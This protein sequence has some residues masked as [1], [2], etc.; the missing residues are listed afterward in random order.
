MWGNNGAFRQ[1]RDTVTPLAR[2]SVKPTSTSTAQGISASDFVRQAESHWNVSATSIISAWGAEVAVVALCMLLY[3]YIRRRWKIIYQPRVKLRKVSSTPSE[4]AAN[5]DQFHL[6]RKERGLTGP[7]SDK[8]IKEWRRKKHLSKPEWYPPGDDEPGHWSSRAPRAEIGFLEWIVP[9][10]RETSVEIM[11]I[12]PKWCRP[13]LWRV[14]PNLGGAARAGQKDTATTV[15]EQDVKLLRMLGLDAVVYLLFLRLLKYLFA[16][17]SVLSVFLALSNYYINTQTPY[18]STVKASSNN[19]VNGSSPQVKTSSN[20]IDNPQ[21]L[22]AANIKSNGLIVHISFE[23]VVTLLVMVFALKASAHHLELIQEWTH[24]NFNEV[25]FKT[26]M[27]TNLALSKSTRNGIR[28]VSDAKLEI[29][30]MVLGTGKLMTSDGSLDHATRGTKMQSIDRDAIDAKVWFAMHNM[31][32][33]HENMEAFKDKYFKRAM[34]AVALETLGGAGRGMFYDSCMD[35]ICG[36]SKT[37]KRRVDEAV[38]KKREIESKQD[39]IR[40]DQKHVK[41][42]DLTGTI[43]SAFITVPTAK[44]AREIL[45]NRKEYMKQAGYTLQRAP[46]SHNVLWKNL[47]KDAKSRHSHAVMGKAALWTICFFNTVPV[48]FIVLLTNIGT[49]IDQYPK[50][51]QMEKESTLWKVIFTLIEGT[52]PAS[53]AALFSYFLP[54]L[55]RRVNKWSGALTRGELDRAVIRQ[56]FVFMLV[57]NFIVFSLLGVLY[58]TYLSIAERIGAESISA[59][60]DSLGDLPAKV[61]K[62]YI[63]ESL[64]WLSWYPIRSIVMWLQLL[65]VPRL[66]IMTPQI[67]RMQTP[68][69]LADVAHADTFELFAAA[70]GLVYAPLAPLVVILATIHFWSAHLVHTQALKFVNDTKETD[71]QCWKILIN[72]LLVATVLMHGMMVLTVALKTRSS[73]MA[74]AAALPVLAIAIFKLYLSKHYD[75]DGVVFSKY[76][77]KYKADE[78]GQPAAHRAPVYKHDLLRTDWMPKGKTIRNEKLLRVAM[79]RF[80]NLAELFGT[81]RVASRRRRRK[82]A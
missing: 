8:E 47:E 66:L 29:R 41:Y 55:M 65:Q 70:V 45:N 51:A 24:M 7:V 22:T 46:R 50:L 42:T 33:L 38:K 28:T 21:L 78:E 30:H 6:E 62:A 17:I 72:R 80:P 36:R 48:M 9:S 19:T 59:I 3:S 60:Y 5:M 18:G 77:D 25:S 32:A 16:T 4:K 20:I 73:I 35:R 10:L 81:D 44:L 11:S 68:N 56:L 82:Q 43:T 74:A 57:S 71:G 40:R 37:A 12:I 49:A 69:D 63:S 13:G 54:Y 2:D 23:I 1:L 31:T 53:V 67:L 39:E 34:R 61:T 15:L 52:L 27:V 26:L 58:E 64:Y 14:K 75:S 76:I 79:Q